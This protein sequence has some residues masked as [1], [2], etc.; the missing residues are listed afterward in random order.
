MSATAI[1]LVSDGWV[2]NGATAPPR[3]AHPPCPP[4]LHPPASEDPRAPPLQPP[5]P[6]GHQAASLQ[7]VTGLPLSRTPVSP[8]SFPVLSSPLSLPRERGT[9]WS[10]SWDLCLCALDKH[11]GNLTLTHLNQPQLWTLSTHMRTHTHTY[12]QSGYR[13]GG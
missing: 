5:R 13:V 2:S 1:Q 7:L 3:P 4:A 10:F 11:T 8:T 9:K 12:T 6:L